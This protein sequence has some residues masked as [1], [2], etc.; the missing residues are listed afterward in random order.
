MEKVES[1]RPITHKYPE[2][3]MH[4][5]ALQMMSIESLNLVHSND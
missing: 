4:F 2:P 1:S 3:S 5:P